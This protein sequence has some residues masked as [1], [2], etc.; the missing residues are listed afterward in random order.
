MSETAQTNTE[1]TIAD[2]ETVV[3]PPAEEVK[4]IAPEEEAAQQFHSM[5][6]MFL[7]K[8][9][10]IGGNAAK[11]VL[12]NIIE[13]PLNN[14][15]LRFMDKGEEGLFALGLQLLSSNRIITDKVLA[16]R[17][18]KVESKEENK[19]TESQTEVTNV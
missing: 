10:S 4:T 1:A 11:R 13:F 17:Q 12:R 8:L 3:A 9:D 5:F 14:S 18:N 2:V 7:R 15:K 6:P 19:E 16:E